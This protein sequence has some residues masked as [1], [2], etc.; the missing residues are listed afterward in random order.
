MDLH[1]LD[2]M[3]STPVPRGDITWQDPQWSRFDDHSIVRVTG[4]IHHQAALVEA[5][6]PPLLGSFRYE[7]IATLLPEPDNPHDEWAVK[8]MIGH[9]HV[10]YL[11]SNRRLK[12]KHQTIRDMRAAGEPT[13]YIGFVRRDVFEETDAAPLKMSLRIPRDGKLYNPLKPRSDIG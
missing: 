10:G 9:H 2:R 5:T 3:T 6:D 8:V 4:T 7:C 1:R 12:R 13:D 11:A